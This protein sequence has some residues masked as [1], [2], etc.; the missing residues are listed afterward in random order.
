MLTNKNIF[1][2][3]FTVVTALVT[4]NGQ[5]VCDSYTNLGS[6]SPLDNKPW[7]NLNTNEDVETAADTFSRLKG[8]M[9]IDDPFNFQPDYDPVNDAYCFNEH[10]PVPSLSSS[11]Q[12]T[13]YYDYAQAFNKINEFTNDVSE[14]NNRV[15][16]NRIPGMF[17]RMCFHDNSI[18]PAQ[19]DF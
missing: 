6:N 9:P 17:L 7:D 13:L 1:K 19:P 16:N 11:Q 10:Y 18:D 2:F 5:N 4:A 12:T 15:T 8:L 14:E 3:L